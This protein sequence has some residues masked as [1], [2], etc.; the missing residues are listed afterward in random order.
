MSNI[1]SIILILA[2]IG[3]FFGYI[4]PT[5]SGAGGIKD[6]Q[7]QKADYDKALDNS[8]ALQA[9]RDKLLQKFNSLDQTDKDK[10]VK[11]LPDNIDNVRLIIDID[12]IARTHGMR[13]RNFTTDTGDKKET[14]GKDTAPYGTLTLTFSTTASYPVFLQ[15]LSDLEHS[16]RIINVTGIQFTPGTATGPIYDYD[17]TVQTYWLK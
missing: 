8:K 16:L 6:L 4:D 2:S 13:I 3:L 7:A 12:N 17:V 15:F 5:Y 1:V 10:L 14:I 9:E 11:L